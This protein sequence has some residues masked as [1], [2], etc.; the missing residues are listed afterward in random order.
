[1][2]GNIRQA[3]C[4]PYSMALIRDFRIAARLLA[5][6]KTW[7]AV[8]LLAL[9][10]GLG[11]HVAIFSVVG[12]MIRVPLPYHEPGQL[13]H[14]PQTSVR[15]GF[16]E[17]SVSLQ[18]V[19][20][21]QAAQGIASIGAYQARPMA[22]SGEGEPQH[23]DAMQGHSGILPHTGRQNRTRSYILAP[24]RSGIRRERRSSLIRLLAGDVS[25]RAERPRTK[26]S[27]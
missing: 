14:I 16:S 20:H 18:D 1:M 4:V 10:L 21:W 7:T 5:K 19:R 26:H 2:R 13:V 9:V 3:T 24:G 22:F 23:L 6:N 12:L 27:P 15:R 25:R 8:A 17:A 11:A